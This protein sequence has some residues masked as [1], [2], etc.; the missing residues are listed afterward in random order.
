MNS[1]SHVL[2]MSSD[3]F[4]NNGLTQS[5]TKR[6]IVIT[7]GS[8]SFWY[9]NGYTRKGKGPLKKQQRFGSKMVSEKCKP[10][11]IFIYSFVNGPNSFLII[12][13]S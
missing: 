4:D 6:A 12:Y 1:E 8:A 11:L 10:S 5:R 3:A 2:E 7:W 13:S 9:P